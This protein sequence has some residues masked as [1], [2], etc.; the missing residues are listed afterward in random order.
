MGKITSE[1][2][3]VLREF[4]LTE[5]E[6]LE[7]REAYMKKKKIVDWESQFALDA[8]DLKVAEQLKVDPDEMISGKIEKV[9]KTICFN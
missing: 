5:K 3:K 6:Y 7:K 2:Q 8:T 1:E 9:A 4:R